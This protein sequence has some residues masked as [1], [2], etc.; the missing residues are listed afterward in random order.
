MVQ[1]IEQQN[2]TRDESAYVEHGKKRQKVQESGI[3]VPVTVENTSTAANDNEL[4]VPR[5]ASG[6]NAWSVIEPVPQPAAEPAAE[7]CP[8]RQGKTKVTDYNPE[9]KI[10]TV[11][12]PDGKCRSF[13]N[14]ANDMPKE[15]MHILGTPNDNLT[16]DQYFKHHIVD[17]YCEVDLKDLES[18]EQNNKCLKLGLQLLLE[19][20]AHLASFVQTW[21]E[22]KQE[23]FDV[24]DSV[25]FVFPYVV[26]VDEERIIKLN[27]KF[28]GVTAEFL[29]ENPT[30]AFLL[31]GDIGDQ[32]GQDLEEVKIVIG[33]ASILVIDAEFLQKIA[34]TLSSNDSPSMSDIYA[35]V[36]ETHYEIVN[37][38]AP[39][40]KEL[41]CESCGSWL[42]EDLVSLAQQAIDILQA[43]EFSK[44]HNFKDT[45]EPGTTRWGGTDNAVL[46]KF[47]RQAARQART[48]LS[49]VS[50]TGGHV[51]L[52]TG[53]RRAE[54]D[55]RDDGWQGTTR[56]R[57]LFA[58]SLLWVAQGYTSAN[59]EIAIKV[60]NSARQDFVLFVLVNNGQRAIGHRECLYDTDRNRKQFG[61]PL[62]SVC[63]P[64][65]V[66]FLREAG[67]L[68]C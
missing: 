18:K 5:E 51:N 40:L 66:N 11:Q 14:V 9:T 60:Y 36:V 68:R 45:S 37:S 35:A 26:R 41:T 64:K 42:E 25:Y 33:D 65:A 67:I 62:N 31:I 3:P 55:L 1:Q 28:Q 15:F 39:E 61:H 22:S 8:L 48:N 32:Y 49:L 12:D 24:D 53:V 29:Q 21:S 44:C 59:M 30:C 47:A 57:Q 56:D 17:D 20:A 50:V 13:C 23:L 54:V 7:P 4:W 10:L 16:T 27:V 43:E 6:Q 19:M 2:Q 46:K 63:V 38:T 52:G 34:L 58:A